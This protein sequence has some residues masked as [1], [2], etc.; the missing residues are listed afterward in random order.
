[1][2][3]VEFLTGRMIESNFFLNCAIVVAFWVSLS[4]EFA[5]AVE[6]NTLVNQETLYDME[7]RCV[8]TRSQCHNI[9]N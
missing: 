7:R 6:N 8:I 2:R 3:Y 9:E 1:M 5:M 4:S